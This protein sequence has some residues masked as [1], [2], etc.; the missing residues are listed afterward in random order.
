MRKI[1]SDIKNFTLKRNRRFNYTI[2]IN[3]NEVARQMYLNEW[4]AI[5]WAKDFISSWSSSNLVIDFI[6]LE[7]K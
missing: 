2:H 3:G 7:N 6:T 1:K 5:L 4:E